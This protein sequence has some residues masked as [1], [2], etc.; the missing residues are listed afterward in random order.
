[1][2]SMS[3][4]MEANTRIKA[5]IDSNAIFS[6]GLRQ[7]LSDNVSLNVCSE[8]SYTF[9]KYNLIYSFYHNLNEK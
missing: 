7:K 4:S 5:K 3:N 6:A 8:V 1:M 9:F 2:Y